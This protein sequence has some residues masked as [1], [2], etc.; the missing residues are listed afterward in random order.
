MFTYEIASFARE[1][2]PTCHGKGQVVDC[3]TGLPIQYKCNDCGGS[4]KKNKKRIE[5]NRR[6]S[7]P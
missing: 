4:G 3:S 1:N 2:C 6:R 7:L 5:E